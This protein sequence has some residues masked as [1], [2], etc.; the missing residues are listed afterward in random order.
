MAEGAYR[1]H[2]RAVVANSAA[3]YGYTLTIW[4]T[5]AITTHA[6]GTFPS[7]TEALLLLTGAVMGFG[8]VGAFASGGIN[9]VLSPRGRGAVRVWGGI[10]LPSV[11]LSIGLVTGLTH[12]VSGVMVW[13]L[14]GFASTS[15][16]LLAIAGQFWLATQRGGVPEPSDPAEVPPQ[17]DRSRRDT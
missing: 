1:R 12:L 5:G 13:P 11:G 17:M 10:H 15:I 3:P 4:T 16:Y 2:L 9:G 8:V 14:V 6:A 7:T